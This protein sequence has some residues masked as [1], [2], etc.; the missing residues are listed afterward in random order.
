MKHFHREIGCNEFRAE[1]YVAYSTESDTFPAEPMKVTSNA[2][3]RGAGWTVGSYMA[4]VIFRFGTNVLLAWM[5]A[6]AI[7]GVMLIINTLKL[8]I[9]LMSDVGIQQN[10][11]YSRNGEDPD[12]LNTAWTIQVLRGLLIF[13]LFLALSKPLADF[14]KIPLLAIQISAAGSLFAGANSMSLALALK[15]MNFASRNFFDAAVDLVSM[16]AQVALT[17]ASPTLW[18]LVFGSVLGSIIRCCASFYYLPAQKHRFR[19]SWPHVREIMSFGKWIFVSSLGYF[20]CANSD[21]LYL[22]TVTSLAVLGVYGIARNIA[23]LPTALVVRLAYFIV[24]PM[25]SSSTAPRDSHRREAA[26]PR[27]L[28]LL[29]AVAGLSVAIAGADLVIGRIYDMRYHAAGWMLSILL[30]GV[31]ISVLCCLNE[32]VLLGF[33]KPRYVAWAN[34][35]KLIALAVGLPLSFHASGLFGAVCLIAASDIFRYVPLL[36]GQKRERFSFFIQDVLLTILL[37]GLVGFWLL[38]RHWLGLGLPFDTFGAALP[39]D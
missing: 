9:E 10:V 4:S 27:L 31:W 35:F 5:L 37:L 36:L 15:K 1:R 39:P 13:L 7:F 38:L 26:R 14:Y 19:W 32:A 34:G 20:A 23:D 29:L 33:G 16:A 3:L 12:F 6:P 2:L 28:F 11:V 8:G 22:A 25:V 24:F 30:L 21:R 18:S 17:Y